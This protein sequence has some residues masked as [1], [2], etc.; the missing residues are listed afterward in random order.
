M[1]VHLIV[2]DPAVVPA[3][4]HP[5]GMIDEIGMSDIGQQIHVLSINA[6]VPAYEVLMRPRV[7]EGVS[8]HTQTMKPVWGLFFSCC[9]HDLAGKI[10]ARGRC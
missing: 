8:G 3:M 7:G 6:V 9:F 2:Y 10:V 4:T 1:V 5:V